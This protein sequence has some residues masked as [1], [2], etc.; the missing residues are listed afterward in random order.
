MR[1]YIRKFVLCA[2]RLRDLVEPGS[3]T[4][5]A[6]AFLKASVRAAPHVLAARGP[7]R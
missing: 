1:N 4:A 7:R 5:R 3:L 6:A 2:A